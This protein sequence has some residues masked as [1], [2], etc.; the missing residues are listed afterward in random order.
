ME[1]EIGRAGDPQFIRRKEEFK[2]SVRLADYVDLVLAGGETN[3]HYLVGNSY[4]LDRDGL[5]GLLDD[6]DYFPDYLADPDRA[7]R[8]LF[9]FGPAGTVT[10]LHHDHV[11][12]ILAQLYGR[13]RVRLYPPTQTPLMYNSFKGF[14]DVDCEVPDFNKFPRFRD[15]TP[16]DVILNPGEALFIPI[17]WWHHVRSLEVSMNVS[18]LNFTWMNWS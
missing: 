8:L 12:S 17:D 15:A 5:R 6:I 1:V 7:R 3:D 18:L 11:N 9:W 4:N 10:P 16:M 2:R 13:K 14:S